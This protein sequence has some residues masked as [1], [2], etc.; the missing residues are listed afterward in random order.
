MK[1]QKMRDILTIHN[2]REK[3]N[4]DVFDYKNTSSLD[5][6][7]N[8]NNLSAYLKSGAWYNTI[9]ESSNVLNLMQE[10]SNLANSMSNKVKADRMVS[11][12]CKFLKTTPIVKNWL[13]IQEEFIN[14]D[15]DLYPK[16]EEDI[17]TNADIDFGL[18]VFEKVDSKINF[19]EKMR[20]IL[21]SKPFNAY[22][23][24]S[25]F[26]DCHKLINGPEEYEN[27][28]DMV[29][30]TYN[31]LHTNMHYNEIHSALILYL[32]SKNKEAIEKYILTKKD[33][34]K[35]T[36]YCGTDDFSIYELSENKQSNTIRVI[37]GCKMFRVYR[38]IN[39]KNAKLFLSGVLAGLKRKVI[40]DNDDGIIDAFKFD[41]I[42]YINN[43]DCDGLAA[44]ILLIFK[45]S[46]INKESKY[47]Y[48]EE[49]RKALEFYKR[50]GELT[51]R[52]L[53]GFDELERKELKRII[54][55]HLI[56]EQI[57]KLKDSDIYSYNINNTNDITI[58]Q[59]FALAIIAICDTT[60]PLLLG[61]DLLYII[62][63][64]K[65]NITHIDFEANCTHNMCDA[66]RILDEYLNKPY[67][68]FSGIDLCRSELNEVISLLKTKDNCCFKTEALDESVNLF[69]FKTD[70]YF[71]RNSTIDDKAFITCIFNTAKDLY[72]HK[73]KD[74][75]AFIN[76]ITN[77]INL[78]ICNLDKDKMDDGLELIDIFLDMIDKI[79]YVTEYEIFDT[80]CIKYLEKI[81]EI[82]GIHSDVLAG[83]DLLEITNKL[84][85]I[86]I[87]YNNYTYSQRLDKMD[88]LIEDIIELYNE[89]YPEDKKSYTKMIKELKFRILIEAS[90]KTSFELFIKRYMAENDIDINLALFEENPAEYLN[91]DI[92]KENNCLEL[93]IILLAYT[94][95][96][97]VKFTGY[98]TW[99]V[100][101]AI[102]SSILTNLTMY[103]E[104]YKECYPDFCRYI[105]IILS[106]LNTIK[107]KLINREEIIT[108]FV[109][110]IGQSY[111][112]IVSADCIKEDV[113]DPFDNEYFKVDMKKKKEKV[114][115]KSDESDSDTD[116]NDDDDDLDD[117]DDD[118]D[119]D[120]DWE[121][122][123]ED[124]DK[125]DEATGSVYH[126]EMIFEA[127]MYNTILKET[128]KNIRRGNIKTLNL[129]YKDKLRYGQTKSYSENVDIYTQAGNMM[130]MLVDHYD[131]ILEYEAKN[132]IKN[133]VVVNEEKVSKIRESK[134]NAA[135][136]KIKEVPGKAV[137]AALNISA[138]LG[139][140]RN[141]VK[142]KLQKASNI[143][144]KYSKQLDTLF[145]RM[146]IKAK[147]STASKNRQAII[148][149]S[150]LPSLSSLIKL[151]SVAGMAT[152]I[153]QPVI[154]MITLIGG[155]GCSIK[156]NREEREN[157]M[158]ELKIQAK[159]VDKQIQ[160]AEDSKNYELYTM[161]L[162]IKNRINKEYN[163][164]EYKSKKN[165]VKANLRKLDTKED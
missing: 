157:I 108:D 156:A 121:T 85:A 107:G 13:I 131:N 139:I 152:V 6:T 110:E 151:C 5:M 105:K 99:R 59:T 104:E 71:C 155:I 35:N 34:N 22:K 140:I 31:A 165:R 137:G 159:V 143:D 114:K 29:F 12:T 164:I 91:S 89:K 56:A 25:L 115:D 64:I 67:F 98:P 10:V 163:R 58:K 30:N 23:L 103:S 93:L 43:I 101:Q 84:L 135:I 69:D 146:Y 117:M 87:K 38:D 132:I 33:F 136:N 133:G 90:N 128:V 83:H 42:P 21:R 36:L 96:D 77:T 142:S 60:S 127:V 26:E 149:G 125:V 19:T 144:K 3:S 40:D 138:D 28:I 111:R 145:D 100:I 80:W 2:A 123:N 52:V 65:E 124:P 86:Q 162:K 158:D 76:Y 92:F 154:G 119:D 18:R 118:T 11:E 39:I 41:V 32:Y 75:I 53:V 102:L 8:E 122:Y 112:M 61:G 74:P 7:L 68:I 44:E 94:K 47:S 73:D 78:S 4:L 130:N 147:E 15:F 129:S 72:M 150:L 66:I 88:K 46:L 9:S 141:S 160:D 113:D 55:R 82:I 126:D 106:I 48:I 63:K 20:E 116:D 153:G 27:L 16:F 57:A 70:T 109:S 1:T 24:Y 148:K 49:L 51:D 134:T 95:Y 79:N 45:K 97:S 62:K 50:T 37:M 120:D 54:V 14:S 81:Y 17:N 161:L